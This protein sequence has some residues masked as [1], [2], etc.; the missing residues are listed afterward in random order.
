VEE[1]IYIYIDREDSIRV[2]QYDFIK[3]N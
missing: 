2:G 1:K 3:K